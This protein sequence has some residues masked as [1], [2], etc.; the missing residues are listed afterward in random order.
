MGYLSFL[1][2]FSQASVIGMKRNCPH[3]EEK[4][5]KNNKFKTILCSNLDTWLFKKS[6]K[7]TS[8][9]PPLSDFAIGEV[10]WWKERYIHYE[11]WLVHD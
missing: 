9:V 4:G 1:R 11:N 7:F 8:C 6:K 2:F 10:R 5:I 3:L